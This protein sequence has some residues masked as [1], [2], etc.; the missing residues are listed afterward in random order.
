LV[1]FRGGERKGF[2][3]RGGEFPKGRGGRN[4]RFPPGG[5]TA[6]SGNPRGARFSI[7]TGRIPRG[8]GPTFFGGTTQTPV[9]GQ[10]GPGGGGGARTMFPQTRGP[11]FFWASRPHALVFGASNRE[12][13]G[14][15]PQRGRGGGKQKKKKTK[16]IPCY[17]RQGRHVCHKGG[18]KQEGGKRK[19]KKPQWGGGEGWGGGTNGGGEGEGG[20]KRAFFRAGPV[21]P[22]G[23]GA[24]LLP[25]GT[26]PISSQPIWNSGPPP[27]LWGG[28]HPEGFQTRPPGGGPKVVFSGGEKKE[29]KK[30]NTGPGASENPGGRGKGEGGGGARQP[31]GPPKLYRGGGAL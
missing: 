20:R 4:E 18:K 31:E 23:G 16:G 28:T 19:R 27:D 12:K 13:F 6:R 9:A 30:G 22:G 25:F 29:K 14:F 7:S 2:P 24:G 11:F 5:G 1:R 26:P 21:F 15:F 3:Q 8:G 17:L 10:P